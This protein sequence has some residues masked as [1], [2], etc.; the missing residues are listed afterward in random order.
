[1]RLWGSTRETGVPGVQLLLLAVPGKP[2]GLL[3]YGLF[4]SS[5]EGDVAETAS[6]CLVVGLFLGPGM[7]FSSVLTAATSPSGARPREP[8]SLGGEGFRRPHTH[9]RAGRLGRRTSEHVALGAPQGAA[10]LFPLL[11][12]KS[13]L[14]WQNKSPF[15]ILEQTGQTPSSRRR[16]RATQGLCLI[17]LLFPRTGAGQE[18]MVETSTITK[19]QKSPSCLGMGLLSLPP[20]SPPPL[21]TRAPTPLSPAG[22]GT[23]GP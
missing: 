1:M 19:S 17:D 21:A 15:L 23:D 3:T 13:F 9:L 11:P 2:Q 8:R 6:P 12:N 5:E 16:N 22:V 4:C 10:W 14:L 18:A 7:C 20:L